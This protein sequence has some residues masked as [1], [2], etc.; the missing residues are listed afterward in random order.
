MNRYYIYSH[1]N[2]TTGKCFYIGKGT[3]ERMKDGK[4]RNPE[5]NEIAE[6]YGLNGKF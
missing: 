1:I 4:Q 2:P 5:W 3:K 6:R